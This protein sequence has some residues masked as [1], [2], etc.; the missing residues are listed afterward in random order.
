MW[1]TDGWLEES[2]IKGFVKCEQGIGK[3]QEIVWDPRASNS[4]DTITTPVEQ[5]LERELYGKGP[6]SGV[7]T[8]S[9]GTQPG[10]WDYEGTESG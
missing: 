10:H 6:L 1:E 2:L 5:N 9:Q 4:W 8:F 7:E 3:P